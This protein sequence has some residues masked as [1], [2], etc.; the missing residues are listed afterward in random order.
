MLNCGK[1]VDKS[2]GKFVGNMWESYTHSAYGV[3]FTQKLLKFSILRAGCGKVLQWVLHVIY[4][5]ENRRFYTFSTM[6]I[7][8]ITN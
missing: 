6:P 8:T 1:G 4:T 3:S 5:R 2:V 7:T